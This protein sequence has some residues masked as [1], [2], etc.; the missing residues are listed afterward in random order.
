MASPKYLSYLLL[1]EK[2]SQDKVTL[3]QE[4]QITTEI[5]F[6]HDHFFLQG[7][8]SI[9]NSLNKNIY[10]FFDILAEYRKTNLMTFIIVPTI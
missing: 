6:S 7:L 3:F 10:L 5:V 1:Y 2:S 9:S 8:K 4:S